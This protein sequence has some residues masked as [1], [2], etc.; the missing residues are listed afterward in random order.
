MDYFLNKVKLFVTVQG[1]YMDHKRDNE[2]SPESQSSPSSP[3]N[4]GA[5]YSL[6]QKTPDSGFKKWIA[7]GLLVMVLAGAGYVASKKMVTD[8]GQDEISKQLETKK[9]L[10]QSVLALQDDDYDAKGEKLKDRNDSNEGKFIADDESAGANPVASPDKK[11]ET[12]EKDLLAEP[13]APVASPEASAA[14]AEEDLRAT[15]E[16]QRNQ[17][18]ADSASMQT[19]TDEAVAREAR[20][21]EAIRKHKAEHLKL[22]QSYQNQ[23]DAPVQAQLGLYRGI[24]S[25][26]YIHGHDVH[27]IDDNGS[28]ID[29]VELDTP[30]PGS[31]AI[32]RNMIKEMG[33]G[34]AVIVYE[35][36]YE[37]YDSSGELIK[38]ARFDE[39]GF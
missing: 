1:I 2:R 30:L 29:H 24:L 3:K 27:W 23:S 33:G 17:L 31:A 37:V 19:L 7:A 18:A 8:P 11:V 35:K 22:L 21:E 39:Q 32:A 10:I 34:V 28:I 16:A 36:G 15:E 14:K 26:C 38:A 4:Q 9:E 12:P 13:V 5:Y 6:E 25:K 20:A